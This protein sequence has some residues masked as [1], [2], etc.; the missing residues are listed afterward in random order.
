VSGTADKRVESG[1]TTSG[2][3]VVEANEVSARIETDGAES[4][5]EDTDTSDLAAVSAPSS[6][7]SV[8]IVDIESSEITFPNELEV[9]DDRSDLV[10]LS[11]DIVVE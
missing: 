4:V 5:L 2:G 9:N 8:E 7:E 1:V 10:A 6:S 11:T 3:G